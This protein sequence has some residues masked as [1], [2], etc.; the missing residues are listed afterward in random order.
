MAAFLQ[1]YYEGSGII[2]REI[3][4]K[5]MPSGADE[6][7]AWLKQQRGGAADQVVCGGHI[8][9]RFVRIQQADERREPVLAAGQHA[10]AVAQHAGVAIP[11]QQGNGAFKVIFSGIHRGYL[12]CPK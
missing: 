9:Q 5:D 7:T 12:L 1:Q 10:V 2:P 3:L 4:V 11:M 8:L 6:L